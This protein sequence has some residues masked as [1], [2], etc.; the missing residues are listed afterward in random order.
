MPSFRYRARQKSNR[1]LVNGTIEAPSLKQATKTLRDQ[2]LLV[3]KVYNSQDLHFNIP[4]LNR[5]GNKDRVL[6]ARQFAVMMR[7]GLPIMSALRAIEEQTANKT[8]RITVGQIS[9]DIQGGTNL[10]ESFAKYPRVFP[11]VFASVTKVGERAGK[12]EEVLERLA[13]QLEKDAELLGKVRSAMIYPAFVMS[14]LVV[15]IILIML[16][17]IP[18]L[19]VL[20]DDVALELPLITRLL[21]AT[22]DLMGRY[23]GLVAILVIGLVIGVRLAI[24]RSL[25]IARLFESIRLK[26]PIFGRLY[27]QMMMA[28]FTHTLAT[29]LGAG[30]PMIEAMKTTATTLNSPIYSQS[31]ETMTKEVESGQPISR[32]LVADKHFP[33]MIGHMA[34]IGEKSGNLDE[35]LTTIAGFFDQEVEGLTRNLSALLEPILMIIMAVGVGLVVASV[36]VPIY[37]LVSA[38]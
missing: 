17:V 18:Q 8:L 23:F 35:I 2:G 7:A 21:L 31:L 4:F 30:L 29:L 27:R 25:K 33:P 12:L 1:K 11:P 19:K 15:V 14:S 20:F 32:L 34:A 5:V 28:R 16:Y 3:L 13:T 10:S 24:A 37:N 6:F 22:S 9:H 26:I 38:V 36:I